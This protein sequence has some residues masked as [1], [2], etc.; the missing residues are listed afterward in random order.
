MT[1]FQ[2]DWRSVETRPDW[3]F[4]VRVALVVSGAVLVAIGFVLMAQYSQG[5]VVPPIAWSLALAFIVPGLIL[6]A[7]GA[8]IRGRSRD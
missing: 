1:E 5:S 2:N 7:A 3:R 4:A 6:A 8:A